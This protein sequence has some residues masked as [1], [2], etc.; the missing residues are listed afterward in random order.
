MLIQTLGNVKL[1]STQDYVEELLL[2]TG[3]YCRSCCRYFFLLH[4]CMLMR[5]CRQ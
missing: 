5:Y 2:C 1:F 4:V 3:G